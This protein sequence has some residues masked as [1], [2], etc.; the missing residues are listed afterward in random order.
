MAETAL[1]VQELK[2][3]FDDISAGDLDFTQAAADVANGNKFTCTG[4]ELI[5]AENTDGANPYTVTV[6]SVPDEK[7]RSEDITTYSLAAG[8]KIMI[9][10]GLTNAKGWKQTDGTILIS[11]SNL[12]IEFAVLRL[13]AG[14]GR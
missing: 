4:R 7:N 1:T 2:A 6:T 11:A 12:A 5:F 10:V 14:V 3:P 13:P 8:D 9:A